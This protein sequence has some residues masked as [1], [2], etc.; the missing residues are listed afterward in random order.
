MGKTGQNGVYVSSEIIFDLKKQDRE[1]SRADIEI[2]NVD[3]LGPSYEG[4]VFL[5][6][7]K[8][9]INTPKNDRNNYAGSYYIF[10]HGG[11]YGDVGHCDFVPGRREYDLRQDSDVR[12]QYKY[13]EATD[14]IKKLGRKTN[15]F[16]ITIVPVLY[17]N[18]KEESIPKT[19]IL[20]FEK[21][22]IIS[23]N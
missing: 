18:S 8:A 17:G 9:N 15:K 3:H 11:C 19:D 10:G 1:F 4:R 21:I 12:S 14:L 5:N 2:H 7:T 20:K 13:I 23:Y 6:N 22:G 16:T